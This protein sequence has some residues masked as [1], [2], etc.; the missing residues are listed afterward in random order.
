MCQHDDA[1]V[2][3]QGT[4]RLGD[5]PATCC[6]QACCGSCS[7]CSDDETDSHDTSWE[8]LLPE[9]DT[10]DGEPFDP[11]PEFGDPPPWADLDDWD[12]DDA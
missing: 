3:C 6:H 2:R 12:N 1:P 11:L 4:T 5:V 9:L 10:D 7:R 8:D